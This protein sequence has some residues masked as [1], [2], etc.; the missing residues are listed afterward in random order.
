MIRLLPFVRTVRELVTKVDDGIAHDCQICQNYLVHSR[1]ID[2]FMR[3]I[4]K[5]THTV[6]K[7]SQVV[8]L[9]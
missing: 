9:S 3:N 6:L 7:R 2:G 4:N 1:L 5:A 8:F